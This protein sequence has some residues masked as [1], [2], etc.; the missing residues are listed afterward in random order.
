MKI[1]VKKTGIIKFAK[2]SFKC[3]LGKKG[4]T[5]NKKEGDCKTPKG[6][7]FLRYVMYRSDRVKKPKTNL[8]IY[9][10]KKNHVCCDD[11]KNPYY[12][13]IFQTKNYINKTICLKCYQSI[14][15]CAYRI[16]L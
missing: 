3:L 8:P 5:G 14:N 13:K 12:N 9:I 1:L 15:S 11:P 10:I 16:D 7:F 4:I 6:T 2:Y